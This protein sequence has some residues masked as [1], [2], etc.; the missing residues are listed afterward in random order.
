MKIL[1]AVHGYPPELV[2]GTE[3]GVQALARAAA[4]A[5]HEVTVLAGSVD[6]EPRF[7]VTEDTDHDP[8]SGASI[9]VRRFHRSDLYFDHWQKGCSVEVTHAFREL[10]SEVQP[11]VLHVEH[12][13]RLSNDLVA[14]A[15]REVSESCRNHR[16]PRRAWPAARLATLRK[17][18]LA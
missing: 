14:T 2:G 3:L 11:D 15:A 7:R 12:W 18:Y 8:G 1:L 9:A 5:G 6:H 17:S 4:A 16:R 13:L 10:L